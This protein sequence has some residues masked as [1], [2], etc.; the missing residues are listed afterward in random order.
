MLAIFVL[1]TKTT[2]PRPQIFWVNGALIGKEA[3]LL[4]FKILEV[5]CFLNAIMMLR[6][7]KLPVYRL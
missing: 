5:K 1:T 4:R 6:I 2:Q 3:A 7:F